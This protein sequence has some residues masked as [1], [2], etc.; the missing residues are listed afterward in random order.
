MPATSWWILWWPQAVLRHGLRCLESK[1][2]CSYYMLLL[3][4]I[5]IKFHYIDT[6]NI[7]NVNDIVISTNGTNSIY[8]ISQ[9]VDNGDYKIRR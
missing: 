9:Y 2:F 6:S 4:I 7:S 5:T 1:G 3:H 8:Q